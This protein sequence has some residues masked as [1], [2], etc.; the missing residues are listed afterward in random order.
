M[1]QETNQGSVTKERGGKGW[2]VEGRF[3]REGT[4]GY[5]SSIHIDV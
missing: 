4:Y 3:E 2:E 5:L 1:T